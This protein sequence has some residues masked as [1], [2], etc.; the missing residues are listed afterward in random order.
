MIQRSTVPSKTRIIVKVMIQELTVVQHLLGARHCDKDFICILSLQQG[1]EM[2][3]T[4][5][6]I[7]W[8]RRKKHRRG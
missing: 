4:V 2:G 3:V 7:L 6:S 5:S 8:L 1:H